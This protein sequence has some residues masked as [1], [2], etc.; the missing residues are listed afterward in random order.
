MVSGVPQVLFLALSFSLHTLNMW[1]GLENDLV[2][3][4]D[5]YSFPFPDMRAAVADFLYQDFV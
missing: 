1:S 3:Y 5:D 2:A 4:T